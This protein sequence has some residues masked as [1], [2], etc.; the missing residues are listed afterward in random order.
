MSLKELITMTKQI[1]NNG[2]IKPLLLVRSCEN[3]GL[4]SGCLNGWLD[5]KLSDY[6]KKQAK[7]LST[8]FFV[9]FKPNQDYKLVYRS[10]LLR[11][12]ETSDICLGYDRTIN[13]TVSKHIREIHFGT[14]EGFF[15][16]G[17]SKQE[18]AVLNKTNHMF[19]KG[20][21]WVDVKF[22]A[23][24]FLND[25]YKNDN[26]KKL[27]LAF[28]HGGFIT[29]LLYLSGVKNNLPPGSIILL[30]LKDSVPKEESER[31]IKDY[32]QT[33]LPTDQDTNDKHF[34]LY[35][36]RLDIILRDHI[37]TVE[38]IYK[39]PDLTDDVY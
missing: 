37:N 7:Y 38:Y 1:I 16:D 36:E 34:N 29:S 31:L 30:S 3:V 23:L 19:P 15:Y 8:E 12:K 20:E 10:D 28:T 17:L 9:D 5:T 22:R 33:E 24:Q 27:S 32:K 14:Q 2:K 4:L 21:S 11:A 25:L 39:L 26:E 18:K 13:H 35:N 6:G